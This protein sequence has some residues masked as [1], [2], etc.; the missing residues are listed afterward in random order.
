MPDGQQL[1]RLGARRLR[2]IP[3]GVPLDDRLDAVLAQ[4]EFECSE[5]GHQLMT[6]RNSDGDPVAARL[7]AL[8]VG[9]GSRGSVRRPLAASPPRGDQV[10]A[11]GNPALARW[12]RCPVAFR[13]CAPSLAASCQEA[14]QDF[15][16]GLLHHRVAWTWPSGQR[17]GAEGARGRRS[18]LEVR[19]QREPAALHADLTVDRLLP[20]SASGR[21]ASTRRVAPAERSRHS[22]HLGRRRGSGRSSRRSRGRWSR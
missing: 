20:C 3:A 18:S 7:H 5:H 22:R 13:S 16:A 12:L 19:V 15:P 4:L 14:H 17:I 9:M 21:G 6:L 11:Q 10:T 1:P 2:N 8:H